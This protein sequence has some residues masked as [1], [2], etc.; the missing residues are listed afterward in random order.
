MLSGLTGDVS[1]WLD[2]HYSG[3]DTYQGPLDTPIREELN[4]ISQMLDQLNSVSVFVDD[5]RCFDPSSQ[6]Y[7]QYPSRNWLAQWA[8]QNGLNWTIEHDIFIAYK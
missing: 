4:E 5:I 7:S 8:D 2:G 3:G 6:E 1:F